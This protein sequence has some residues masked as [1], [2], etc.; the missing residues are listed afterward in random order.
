M[1]AYVITDS[2]GDTREGDGSAVVGVTS[3]RK[4]A[5]EATENF[6]GRVGETGVIKWSRKDK[7]SGCA[8]LGDH[9]VTYKMFFVNELDEE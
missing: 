3:S 1:R 8:V 6:L 7:H 9:I 2:I 4:T 5:I